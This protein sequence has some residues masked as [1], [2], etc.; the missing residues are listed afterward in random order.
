VFISSN[1]KK[2]KLPHPRRAPGALFGPF[3][4]DK[5]VVDDLVC[6]RQ[7]LEHEFE[8]TGEHEV[9]VASKLAILFSSKIWKYL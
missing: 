7:L 8:P 1:T 9:E 3:L 5:V 2:F 6:R 4:Q